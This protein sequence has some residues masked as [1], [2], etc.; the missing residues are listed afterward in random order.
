[1]GALIA[2][3]LALGLSPGEVENNI[4]RTFLEHNPIRDYTVPVISLSRG[5]KS[6]RLLQESYGETLIEN[7]WKTFFCLST[8]LATGQAMVHQS[9]LLWRALSASSAIPG[10]FPPVLENDRV[11]VDGALIDSFPTST[12]R[13]LQR[14]RVIGIEVCSDYR[15]TPEDITLGT[16]SSLW[17]LLRSRRQAP[18]ILRILM[19]SGT[20]N[21]EAQ[22]ATSRAN[23]DLLVQPTLEGIDM[24]SFAAFDKAVETGYR[25]AM[26]TISQ[27]DLR[28]RLGVTPL[29]AAA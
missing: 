23:A 22:L 2:G 17:H 1:M 24:L 28:E 3:G 19:R 11:L 29:H 5:R 6:N 25:V 20:V 18:P 14:G 9:G 4:R 8:D 13:S 21:S 15:I 12:M 16:R 26:E 7:L 10:V 27:F